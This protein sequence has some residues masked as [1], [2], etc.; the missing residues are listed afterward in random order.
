MPSV[1]VRAAASSIA[2]GMPSRR[3]QTAPAIVAL[4]ASRTKRPIHR[5]RPR[6]EQLDG[7]R[8][9]QVLSILDSFR[10][11]LERGH[12]VDVLARGAER[13]AAGRQDAGVR[14][15]A[16]QGLVEDVVVGVFKKN[17]CCYYVWF[18]FEDESG[19]S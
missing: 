1:A 9:Q 6:H 2:R 5:L 8:L 19:V 16:Q 15:G 12:S 4:G 18:V 13:F 3:R 17:V 10:R 14:I 7:S 11:H